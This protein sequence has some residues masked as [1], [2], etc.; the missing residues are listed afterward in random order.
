[1]NPNLEQLAARADAA[2]MRQRVLVFVA[3]L[4]VVVFAAD[5]LFI[6]PLRATQK[7]L[8]AD[9]AQKQKDAAA[10]AASVRQMADRGRTH[11]DVGLRERRAALQRELAEIDARVVQE[12]KRFTPPERMRGALEGLLR[13][14]PGLALVELRTLAPV[15]LGE[16]GTGTAARS[17]YRH[18]MEITVAGTYLDFY[19]YL[20][21]LEQLPTQLYWGQAHVSVGAYPGATLKLT[22]YT[23]SFDSAWLVV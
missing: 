21:A 10:L 2:P 11:P 15:A 22:I 14:N 16:A 4:L 18:G 23:V 12:R 8:S 5:S 6:A 20:R 3:V 17:L 13:A 1:M 9:I 7:R 19:A